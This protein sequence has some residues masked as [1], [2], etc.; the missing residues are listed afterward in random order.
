MY[1]LPMAGNHFPSALK[2]NPMALFKILFGI[3]LLILISCSGSKKEEEGPNIG[4]DKEKLIE[5]LTLFV[6]EVQGDHFDRA[7][8]YLTPV[9][10][11][12]MFEG[13]SEATP[14]VR[15]QLKAL[16]LSTLAHKAGVR[17]NQGKIE[18]IYE[19]L[20][21][22][23][24]TKSGPSDA[25]NSGSESPENSKYAPPNQNQPLLP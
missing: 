20:P 17:L 4:K 15:R 23:G 6:E 3:I 22:F 8:E 2:S 1:H 10:K 9:E 13:S 12:K 21:N 16:R 24:S 14:M 7:F 25:S 18:G 5:K 19:W 11:A